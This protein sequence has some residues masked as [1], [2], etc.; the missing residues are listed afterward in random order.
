MNMLYFLLTCNHQSIF[1]QTLKKKNI[2]LILL[3]FIL[4]FLDFSCILRYIKLKFVKI[5]MFNVFQNLTKFNESFRISYRSHLRSS[6]I[7][8]FTI[9]IYIY[10]FCQR[11][12]LSHT[13]LLLTS[14]TG[15][16]LVY[17]IH[18]RNT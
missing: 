16:H 15:I 1:E 14:V 4:F 9:Y 11:K 10:M 8:C 17:S 12:H 13:F 2:L 5:Q 7:I 3:S 18:T 6:G